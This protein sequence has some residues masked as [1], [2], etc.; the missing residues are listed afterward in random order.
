MIWSICHCLQHY[1]L[2]SKSAWILV[3]PRSSSVLHQLLS[4]LICPW[5][6]GL[7]HDSAIISFSAEWKNRDVH[8]QIFQNIILHTF[9]DLTVHSDLYLAHFYKKCWIYQSIFYHI[10]HNRGPNSYL[11]NSDLTKLLIKSY[12]K[13]GEI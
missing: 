5:Q 7:A 6:V 13:D 4:K 8:W 2:S 12:W 10:G 1:P 3:L 9:W 11:M